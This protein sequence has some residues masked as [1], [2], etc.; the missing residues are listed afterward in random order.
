MTVDPGLY[1]MVQIVNTDSINLWYQKDYYLNLLGTVSLGWGW[2]I[3]WR[4]THPYGALPD[5]FPAGGTSH[6][7]AYWMMVKVAAP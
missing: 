4:K 3:A 5:P 6:N 2:D 1:W 7:Y